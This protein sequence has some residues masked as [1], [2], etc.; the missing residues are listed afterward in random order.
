M[1]NA[2]PVSAL[3]AAMSEKPEQS[4][5]E[6]TEGAGLS[7]ALHL[8]PLWG[9]AVAQPIFNVLSSSPEFFVAH[10]LT[11]SGLVVLATAVALGFPLIL[12]VLEILVRRFS[13]AAR[14]WF[15]RLIVAVLATITVLGGINLFLDA[16]LIVNGAIASAVGLATTVLYARKEGVRR[17]FSILAPAALV[18]PAQFLLFSPISN[19]VFTGSDEI[20]AAAVQSR[21]PI[22][23]IIFDE[24]NP[25]ALLRADRRVDEV[26][27]PNFAELASTSH[28]F[29]NAT[30]IHKRTVAALPAIL[31][32]KIPGEEFPPPTSSEYPQTLFT[33]LGNSYRFN[34]W[35]TITNLCPPRLCE[36]TDAS[37]GFDLSV[38]VSDLSL[39]YAYILVPPL[40]RDAWLPPLD[41]GW[42]GFANQPNESDEDGHE[43]RSAQEILEEKFEDS[44][45]GRAETFE[46][47]LSRI[48][49]GDAT[50]DFLHILLPHGP[51]EYLSGGKKY[52]SAIEGR[53]RGVWVDNEYLVAVGYQRYLRQVGFVDA[54]VGQLIARLK[55]VGKYDDAMIILT[56]DHGV[57]FNPGAPH[58]EPVGD[59]AAAVYTVPLMI[60]LPGQ[61]EGVVSERY[62]SNV[63][64][65]ATIAD[66]LGESPPWEFAGVSAFAAQSAPITRPRDGSREF[67]VSDF[68]AE[69]HLGWQAA[70]FGE[71]IDLGS[72]MLRSEYAAVLGRD[73]DDLELLTTSSDV[74]L[75]SDTIHRFASVDRDSGFLPVMFSGELEN[76][77]PGTHWVAL[78]LNGTIVAVAPTYE[79]GGE[80]FR[81]RAMLP[82][83]FTRDGRNRLEAFLV[84]GSD[85]AP[86]L[87]RVEIPASE[88]YRLSRDGSTEVIQSMS[89]S[90]FRIEPR[91]ARGY[92]DLLALEGEMMQLRGWAVDAE[93]SAL[94]EAVLIQVNGDD[95]HLA[96]T[97]LRRPDVAEAFDNERYRLSGFQA[98]V[99]ARG[100]SDES[101]S[102]RIFVLSQNGYA[103]EVAIDPAMINALTE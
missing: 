51:Y 37:G 44:S 102:L 85:A 5:N 55:A 38:F 41:T 90:R 103:G 81:I 64:V 79:K 48:A 9:F 87:T 32:G 43:E 61:S 30:G 18:F 36:S 98:L 20:E 49:G 97:R 68:S 2:L 62:V 28:W 77:Q 89:G 29:P 93:S 11:V 14:Q 26:R 45:S 63:D 27:F 95:I 80:P 52:S 34:V 84:Q 24:F 25:T 67:N 31:S 47:F 1:P 19:L 54:L 15:H 58:R 99:P 69:K 71:G 94:P 53:T 86:T 33:W 42:K 23:F 96:E 74:R 39:V 46:R 100:N 88:T 21:T 56:A 66:V 3:K 12:A 17:F 10:R 16:T 65:L 57:A 8:F 75:S 22:V 59:N 40:H 72:T 78:G 35:E 83:D 101:R 50:L 13:E 82:P 7:Q 70:T 76:V 6:V 60:K 91:A 73:L 4:T 92:L